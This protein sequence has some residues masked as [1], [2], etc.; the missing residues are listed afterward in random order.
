MPQTKTKVYMREQ[1]AFRD[2]FVLALEAKGIVASATTIQRDY[3]KLNQQSRITVHAAR[4]WL[5]GEAI[6][7][8]ARIQILSSWLD[9]SSSWLRFG[10]NNAKLD[11]FEMTIQERQVLRSY[12]R[13]N[14]EDQR[15]FL[16]AIQAVAAI[17]SK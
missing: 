3:N 7:T 5:M 13:L 4:K 6:P 14:N 15:Y 11:V 17:K 2:R 12:R 10:E 1:E 8:Q 9:V 16:V